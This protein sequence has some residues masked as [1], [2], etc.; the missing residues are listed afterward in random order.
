M[1]GWISHF[2]MVKKKKPP[3]VSRIPDFRPC[4]IGRLSVVK[5]LTASKYTSGTL[6]GRWFALPERNRFCGCTQ[7]RLARKRLGVSSTRSPHRF[8]RYDG[9]LRAAAL[10][11]GSSAQPF[12]ADHA[13]A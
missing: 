4:W 5:I 3:S 11:K 9:F 8:E 1:V 12:G 13:V 6:A 10:S 2:E 7:K